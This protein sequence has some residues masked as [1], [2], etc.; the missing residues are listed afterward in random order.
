MVP[1]WGVSSP[2]QDVLVQLRASWISPGP[3]GS[4][5]RLPAE[6]RVLAQD[7]PVPTRF[8]DYRVLLEPRVGLDSEQGS[9][10]SGESM[11]QDG[12]AGEC[13]RDDKPV[14]GE[15]DDRPCVASAVAVASK[16]WAFTQHHPLDTASFITEA[17]RRGVDLNPPSL[18]E[19]YR[20]GLLIPF[21]YIT[22]RPVTAPSEPPGSEPQRAGTRLANL[23]WARDTGRLRDLADGPF[24][25]R[26]PFERRRQR[27]RSWWNGL[28][29]SWYQLLVL[30]EIDGLLALRRYHRR[31]AHR[32][33]WLP[34]PHP[35]PARSS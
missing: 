16:A 12:D 15:Q 23:R 6:P 14:D 31:D 2:G 24:M 26:L 28:L 1:P 7:A 8:N 18:R 3:Y 4:T 30:P 21:L 11:Q 13:A 9:D 22:H 10:L 20:R 33:A 34:E 19:L 5:A 27:P 35:G 17:T 32:I 25:S 29:Y